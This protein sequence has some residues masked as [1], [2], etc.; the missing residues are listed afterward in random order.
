MSWEGM[1]A[2]ESYGLMI[3]TRRD[4]CC[5]VRIQLKRYEEMLACLSK[6][7]E[8][9]RMR[10]IL[11]A[12]SRYSTQS[13][14][15]KYL[16][17]SILQSSVAS[18]SLVIML[19]LGIVFI[20]ITILAYHHTRPYSPI[21]F[22]VLSHILPQILLRL[23]EPFNVLHLRALSLC[24]LPRHIRDRLPL[25]LRTDPRPPRVAHTLDLDLGSVREAEGSLAL[26]DRASRPFGLGSLVGLS[27]HF[28]AKGCSG[29]SGVQQLWQLCRYQQLLH[30]RL[31]E[32][33]TPNAQPH[34]CPQPYHR[35]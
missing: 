11:R 8:F 16:L 22:F 1:Y 27:R 29:G 10:S 13:H 34:S 21:L 3:A 14:S 35:T 6:L 19:T 32:L 33:E 31:D 4:G 25:E 18:L 26:V 7:R 9:P 2:A 12:F 20:F 15:T 24:L 30:R 5:C 17:S 23:G 28:R